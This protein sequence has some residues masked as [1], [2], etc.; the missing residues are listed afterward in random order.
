MSSLRRGIQKVRTERRFF[1]PSEMQTSL[2][3]Q[4]TARSNTAEES[5]PSLRLIK[6]DGPGRTFLLHAGDTS[7]AIQVTEHDIPVHVYWGP[8][9]SSFNGLA[10]LLRTGDRAFSPTLAGA[11]WGISL[12]TLPQEYPVYGTSDYRSPALEIYDLA[13]GSRILDL[14]YDSYRVESGKPA[15]EGLPAT[16]ESSEGE[17]E[18]LILVLADKLLGLRVELAYSVFVGQPVIVRS[19]R[20]LNQGAGPLDIRRAL[21][22]SVDFSSSVSRHQWINLYG[23]WG[24]ER[25]VSC[26]SLRPGLQSVGSARGTSS[27]HY[28]PFVALAEHG[29]DENTGDVYAFNLVYSGNWLGQAELDSVQAVRAQIGLNPFDFSWRLEPGTSFQTPE[30]VLLHVSGQGLGGMSR[31]LHRFY[32][33]HLIR[34]Y[35]RDRPRPILINNWEATY[36]NF[37][38]DKLE[39]IARTGAELGLELFVLDD[40]WFGRRD[41]DQSSLGDWMVDRRKLPGGLEDL[42]RRINAHGLDFGLWFEPEMISA[43]SDLYRAHPDW[44]LHAPGRAC[45]ES[46]FQ[47]VLDFSRTDV[48]NYIYDSMV[49][50][51]SSVPIRYVKWDMNRNLTEICSAALPPCQQQETAHRYMLGVYDLMERLTSDFPEI[52]FEGCS[53]GGGRFDPGILHYMPQIWTSDNS[54]AISRL[55]IQYGTS[56]A[57]PLSCMAAHVSAVPNHQVGRTTSLRTRAQVAMTGAFGYELDLTRLTKE[58]RAEV[59]AQVVHYKRHRELLLH[60]DL[61]RL[62]SPYENDGRAAAWMV[63]NTEASEALV[64]FVSVLAIANEPHRFLRLNGLDPDSIYRDS[65]SGTLYQGAVLLH[66]GLPVPPSKGDFV[67]VQWHLLA[68]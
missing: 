61:Y 20:V 67:S 59:R 46:R 24:R 49:A 31:A 55:R 56:L 58:E 47:L 68:Q 42:A 64:T 60:G 35:W 26:Q 66:A 5:A 28:S 50:I 7:Y 51:L 17:A 33:K 8:R 18:T 4:N 34:G 37:D 48:R 21:S 38:T 65:A 9:L 63:V 32:R 2:P 23:S 36:F 62:V 43:D 12:D 25:D 39:Q 16:F 13:T 6:C 54:D 22:A 19:A 41:D 11:P 29:L 44:C 15:L 45:T 57:Y 10:A 3:N 14:R 53:G 1:M 40:G 52:L 27:H 30:A